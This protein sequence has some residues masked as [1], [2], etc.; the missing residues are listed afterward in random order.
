MSVKEMN[1][2]A[3][4]GGGTVAAEGASFDKVVL[5]DMLVLEVRAHGNLAL[6]PSV[7][8]RAM[9]RQALCVGGEVFR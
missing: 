7:A 1:S 8:Y 6:E 2:E 4:H 3:L 5:A 9:V